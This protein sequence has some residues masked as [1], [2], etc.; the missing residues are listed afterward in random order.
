MCAAALG[1]ITRTDRGTRDPQ[2]PARHRARRLWAGLCSHLRPHH[3]TVLLFLPTAPALNLCSPENRPELNSKLYCLKA[4][5]F[6]LY[7]CL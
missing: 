1:V 4:R 6:S 7:V 5:Y 3:G 2:L